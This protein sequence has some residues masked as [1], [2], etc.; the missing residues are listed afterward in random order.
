MPALEFV[1]QSLRNGAYPQGN[2][3]RLVNWYRVPNGNG[4]TLRS[5]L[6]MEAFSSLSG[7][8]ARAAARIDGRFLVVFGG[9]LWEVTADGAATKL[10]DIPDSPET[11]IAGNNGRVTVCANGD[12]FVWNDTLEAL[13]SPSTGA[14]NNVGSVEFFGQR[15]VLTERNGRRVQWS[16]LAAPSQFNALDFAT[17]ESRDDAN[18]R[19]VSFG[20]ELWIFKRQSVERWAPDAGGLYA[21]PGA[22]IDKGLRAFDLV[23][24]A[25]F[26]GFFISDDNK[27]YICAA[28]GT[29]EVVSTP[30]VEWS[31]VNEAPDR[32]FYY[33]DEGREFCVIRFPSRPAWVFDLTTREWHERSQQSGA[34]D[35]KMAVNAF[36]GWYGVDDVGTVAKLAR[37]NA[38]LGQPLVRTAVS[39]VMP[40]DGARP[41]I[42]RFGARCLT[43]TGG[44][45]GMAT[46]RDRGLT[47]SDLSYRSVGAVG[48]Y[49]TRPEWRALGQFR[50]VTV[51]LRTADPIDVEASAEV[52]FA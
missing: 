34:W 9:G 8:Y 28:G 22:T 46:S 17:T 19:A 42:K 26:G 5:V 33:Q 35:V 31:I 14:F 24:R 3:S 48:E 23:T 7:A 18:I 21:I 2:P 32:V 4:M 20:S 12:Y 50:N 6:G 27:A 41:R 1:G 30:A 13:T 16:G 10:A 39:N 49:E 11:T 29:L 40:G 37:V 15:T 51:L 25:D 43:G 38:D 47:F 36:G 52:E 44:Q 45:I